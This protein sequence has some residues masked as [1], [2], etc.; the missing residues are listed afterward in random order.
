MT[1][2]SLQLNSSGSSPAKLGGMACDCSTSSRPC[3]GH[4]ERYEYLWA[5]S[6][7][8]EQISGK[9]FLIERVMYSW[10]ATT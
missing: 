6:T 9:R 2:L 3:P 7:Q 10:K 5:T 4:A 8:G 1:M